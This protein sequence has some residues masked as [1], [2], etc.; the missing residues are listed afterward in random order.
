MRTSSTLRDPV[1]YRPPLLI[2]NV[3]V[4]GGT[5]R[6]RAGEGVSGWT[7]RDTCGGGDR[8]RLRRHRRGHPARATAATTSS[9]SSG[10]TTS[11]APG[12]TTPT[13]AAPA[14]CPRTCTRFSFAPNPDWTAH[15]LRRRRRSGTTCG[16]AS[17]TPACTAHL[18]LR[19]E[20]R[21]GGLGRGAPAVA[22]RHLAG[23]A[24]RPRPGRRRRPAQ[25]AVHPGPARARDVRRQG[26]PLGPLGPRPRPDRPRGSPSSAPARRRSSS[27]RR[28][29]R[30]VGA[31]ARLP[32]HA[33]VGDA[34]ARPPDRARRA[35]AVP[36]RSRP[37]SGSPARPSTGAARRG[38]GFLHPPVMRR[39]QRLAR[40]HLRRPGRRPG[41][42]G[43][44]TPA[45]PM[46]CKRVL[47]SND[48]YPAL[49]R[50]NVER[51]HRRHHRGARRTRWSPPTGAAHPVDTIIFG[52]GFHVTDL[53]MAQRIRGRDGRTLAEAWA[54]SMRA[55]LGTTVA[56]FP[57]LFLLLGPNT[58]LGHTSVVFMIESQLDYLL[59]VLRHLDRTGVDAIEPTPGAQRRVRPA[60]RPADGRH[61]VGA[62]RLQELVPRRDRAQL[63]A[64][65]GLHLAFRLRTRR[66]DPATTCWIAPGATVGAPVMTLAGRPS[67]SP[68][69]P[70]A[71]ASTWPGRP[72]AR[73][74]RVVLVGLEPER[75]PR[76]PTSS[77]PTGSSATSPTRPRWTRRSPA[78]S[79][80]TGRIDVVVANAG[81]ANLG[82]VAV[83]DVEALVRTVE[84]NLIGVIRTVAATLPHVIAGPRLLP[85]RLVGGR[86][87]RAARHGRLLR[88]QGRR[89]AFGN[90]LR[91]SW[92][93]A[94]SRSAPRIR[95][96]STPTW[97]A[98]CSDD[99]PSFRAA[100]ARLPPALAG[101]LDRWNSAP[102]RSSTRS[103]TVGIRCTCRAPSAGCSCCA[104]W[105]TP[106]SATCWCGG[107]L[108]GSSVPRL[109]RPRSRRWAARS[110]AHSA[111]I[112]LLP[113]HP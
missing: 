15:V 30:E 29:R 1:I 63:H 72:A 7:V 97:S 2:G 12:A 5:E 17:P 25:R 78:R 79:S 24:T 88:R 100:L 56:G 48:Y 80:A 86:V 101:P 94:A 76:S 47:L 51:G 6:Y 62:G 74:A 10:A 73:G 53:P 40:R 21:G 108:P 64:V 103:T 4:S 41:A 28:S 66:F 110:G 92:P 57:N 75:L 32:A 90:A 26:V 84:V 9:S 18:R 27:C 38:A 91:L 113:F 20:V 14:T 34:A 37:P 31:A 35:A 65:A 49:A 58:G 93:T 99:L 46:G 43:Q 112:G 71:S 39:G 13:R 52:T 104:P 44:L 77:T 82:T 11:A 111:V 87:H 22:A 60:G 83:G 54:G 55:Y 85:A 70:A 42:A 69:P 106:G 81:I 33:A 36:R 95:A 107:A 61:G 67:S 105:S 8:R 23:H 3:R 59:G 98:T 96:G 102:R 16:A 68:A 19:H 45:Y 89:G 50:A 109:W